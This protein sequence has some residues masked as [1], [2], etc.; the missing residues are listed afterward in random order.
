VAAIRAL[1]RDE[2]FKF[3]SKNE[4][5]S[6][7]LRYL[8]IR[9]GHHKRRAKIRNVRQSA[10]CGCKCVVIAKKGPNHKFKITKSELVHTNGYV[11]GQVQLQAID[12]RRGVE[13]GEGVSQQ[14]VLISKL[15]MTCA[16]L[17]K[18]CQLLHIDQLMEM[19][20]SSLRNLRIRIAD[21]AARKN[22][23]W[24]AGTNQGREM[25]DFI[26]SREQD[27]NQLSILNT[28]AAFNRQLNICVEEFPDSEDVNT[29]LETVQEK[30]EVLHVKFVCWSDINHKLSALMWSID[31]QS[32]IAQQFGDVIF[33]DGTCNTNDL[34]WSLFAPTVIT[35]NGKL[36]PIA[37]GI[38]KEE[39]TNSSQ[40]AMLEMMIE[41]MPFLKEKCKTLFSDQGTS[42]KVIDTVFGEN[43]T[44]GLLCEWH[45][46]LNIASNL[47]N[48]N[49]CNVKY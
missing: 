39:K 23:D 10:K 28:L 29:Y 6:G 4:D 35:E 34:G 19:T 43:K 48:S 26:V 8:C 32:Q 14:L 30:L 31:Y 12:S 13:L 40:I 21:A 2:Q 46:N 41:L 42:Q 3:T 11:P 36:Y 37:F 38:I 20:A 7:I 22:D 9:Y 27:G 24:I 44:K 18:A 17:R 5:K 33:W 25:V 1:E 49:P 47:S 45:L 16:Q 15:G